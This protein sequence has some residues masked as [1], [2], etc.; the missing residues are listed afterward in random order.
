ML[1]VS[2]IDNLSKIDKILYE[3]GIHKRLLPSEQRVDWDVAN[4]KNCIAYLMYDNEEE[5]GFVLFMPV[6]DGIYLVDIGVLKRY[7]GKNAFLL[8]QMARDIFFTNSGCDFIMA[9]IKKDNPESRMF[10][11]KCG[12]RDLYSTNEYFYM[13]VK[14]GRSS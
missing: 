13:G 10:A 7:R 14:H 3:D 6:F 5:A 11:F 4:T 9:K 1:R 12:L 8:A 2:R